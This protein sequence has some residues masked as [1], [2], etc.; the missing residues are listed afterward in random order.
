MA[1]SFFGAPSSCWVWHFAGPSGAVQTKKGPAQTPG[2]RP[3]VER[4]H[5]LSSRAARV[6]NLAVACGRVNEASVW[7]RALNTALGREG[8]TR[9]AASRLDVVSGHG[10]VR[11]ELDAN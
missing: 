7:T 3:L 5:A 2:P 8:R 9:L 1:C 4:G 6:P 10:A 11:A